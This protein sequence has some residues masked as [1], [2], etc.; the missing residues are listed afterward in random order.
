MIMLQQLKLL[1]AD[2]NNV[3]VDGKNLNNMT[4][5]MNKELCKLILWLNINK[6][7]LNIGKTHYDI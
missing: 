1:F 6:L 2:D 7:S 4:V 5:S 3:F